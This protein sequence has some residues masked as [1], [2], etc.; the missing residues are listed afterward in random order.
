MARYDK[1]GP[2][3][4]RSLEALD[5]GFIGYNNRLR[6]DQLPVGILEKS[7]NGRVDRNGEWNI[8]NGTDIK[9][10]PIAAGV[11][12]LVLPFSLP[13]SAT[14][15]AG[16]FVT[17]IGYQIVSVGST[18]FTAIGAA[19]NTVGVFF[20]ATG[21]GS[22]SGTARANA[23]TDADIATVSSGNLTITNINGSLYANSGTINLSNV[24]GFS[25]DPNGD[26]AYTK[27]ATNT[28]TVTGSF[29]GS[30]D[31]SV[32]VK[33]P[34]LNDGAV[35][36]EAGVTVTSEVEMI[37]AFNKVIIFRKGDI[38]LEVDLAA[39]NITSSPTINRV[40]NGDYAANATQTATVFDAVAG[41]VVVG[42]ENHGYSVGDSIKCTTVGDSG[43]TLN[44]SFIVAEITSASPDTFTFFDNTVA[45]V[46]DAA[47][48]TYPKFT[49]AVSQG[50]GFIHMPCP[51]F[52]ILHQRRLIV[53]YQFDQS[54]SSGSAT[55]TSRKVFDEL[56][57]SDILDS[58]T[59]DKIYASFRFN[60][61]ASDFTVGVVS[62]TEDSILVFNKNS[63]YRVSGTTNP[64]NSTSQIL[65]NEIGCLSR[66]SIAQVG[67]NVFFLSDNGVYSLEFLD[68]YNLRGTQTPLSEPIQSTIDRINQDAAD[69]AVGVYFDNRYYLA[70]PLDGNDFNSHII[71]YNF[72]T[73]QWESVD[74][75]NSK[76]NF[77]YT[78]LIVAGIGSKRGVYSTNI[79]GGIH[80]IAGDDENFSG[81][82]LVGNDVTITTVG[83]SAEADPILG[84]A[85]TRMYTF[86]DIGRKKFNSFDI[87]AESSEG[88]S[89][90]FSIKIQTENIDLELTD[91]GSLLGNASTFNG[92]STIPPGEDI[93]LR[94]R[95]GNKRAYGAQFQIE[96]TEGRPKIK[97]IKTSATQT[98][99]S[100]N[101]AT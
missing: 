82:A 47:V 34:I 61:G 9:S 66:K 57:V 29:S 80:L 94:G 23:D 67:K 92:G 91:S 7:E 65:T 35:N 26:Q 73:K 97:T 87:Q 3:D 20:T 4:D 8:R 37:Q 89:S 46:A 81:A 90:D 1:Y 32:T 86:S 100:T 71:I 55:I 62:F 68:E 77:H 93:A 16:S 59:Y 14:T 12:A 49:K 79:D 76:A 88:T 78:N 51:E 21:A 74:K 70:V 63:I 36:Y 72:L 84:L 2:Q 15:T 42:L 48:S 75:I 11:D 45:D 58:N 19:S 6:P 95:I 69:K 60:A 22:G 50:L 64:V 5:S 44:A 17:G 43:L 99:R 53:P 33:Y 24:N 27:T 28:L 54:G 96:N 52:G 13:E 25:P 98:F 31:T 39:N 30:N 85:K 83:G 10:A 101:P 38:A 56:I 41:K 18:D 40:S